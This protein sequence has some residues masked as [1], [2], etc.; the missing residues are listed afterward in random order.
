MFRKIYK[1]YLQQQFE[2]SFMGVF[3]NP[4]YFSRKCLYH[5]IKKYSI[6]LEGR[7]LDFGCGSKPYKNLFVNSTEYIGI[8]FQN[9]GHDHHKENI[10]LFYDGKHL[11]FSDNSFDSVVCTEVFEHIADVEEVTK[12]LKRVLKTNGKM[13]LT[14]PFVFSEHEMPYDYR[15]YTVNGI[16]NFLE[17]ENFIVL[18]SERLGNFIETIFQLWILYLHKLFSKKN[19]YVN[20]FVNLFILSPF[21]I[22]GVILN[23]LLPNKT[24]LY[25]DTVVLCQKL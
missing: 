22:I 23:F 24:S 9:T 25:L 17:K 4:V 11:P 15:R 7:V 1:L 18:S 6:Q 14:V 5:G 10:D 13:L 2:P 8:D 16:T 3:V 20:I 19:K 21:I 12:E